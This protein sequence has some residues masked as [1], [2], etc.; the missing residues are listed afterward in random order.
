MEKYSP[1]NLVKN[2]MPLFLIQALRRARSERDRRRFAHMSREEAFNTVYRK[3][4][5]DKDTNLRTIF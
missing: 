4:L 3:H 2:V 1:K 5:W